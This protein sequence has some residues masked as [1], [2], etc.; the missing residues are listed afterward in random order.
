[1][2]SYELVRSMNLRE[3]DRVFIYNCIEMLLKAIV[4]RHNHVKKG[5]EITL[6]GR[7]KD[8]HFT[9]KIGF[10]SNIL[11]G[12]N[13]NTFNQSPGYP[14][15]TFGDKVLLSPMDI[16]KLDRCI[17]PDRLGFRSAFIDFLPCVIL[18]LTILTESKTQKILNLTEAESETFKSNGGKIRKILGSINHRAYFTKSPRIFTK[19]E[20]LFDTNVFTQIQKDVFLWDNTLLTTAQFES[21][22]GLG[23][24]VW[25]FSSRIYDE[26]TGQW[27]DLNPWHSD[28]M[29]KSFLNLYNSTNADLNLAKQIVLGDYSE[30]YFVE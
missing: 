15:S 19:T 9:E 5:H 17:N 2:E 10:V 8:F 21:L 12:G 13:L 4:D 7:F 20:P 28:Y 16:I 29:P 22:K 30:I 1:M 3:N 14:L 18:V 24:N 27:S 11:L 6:H 23:E 26:A 25:R